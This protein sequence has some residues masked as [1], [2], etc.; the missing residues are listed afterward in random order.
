MGEE[1][2]GGDNVLASSDQLIPRDRDGRGS[3][4][5]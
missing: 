1:T 4:C 2:E 5:A 3:K